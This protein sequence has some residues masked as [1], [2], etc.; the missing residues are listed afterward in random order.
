MRPVI[1]STTSNDTTQHRWTESQNRLKE[2]SARHN[3]HN[4]FLSCCIDKKLVPKGLEVTFE[5]AIG[6]RNQDF[7]D[8][9]YSK[10]KEF[11]FILMKDIITFCEKWKRKHSLMSRKPK[12]FLKQQ[13]E[14]NHEEILTKG[15]SK[16]LIC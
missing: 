16:N 10:L 8:N 2:K 3:S 6:K 4:Y 14:K 1:A 5:P 13:L 12:K 11:S 15:N 9:W 7:I